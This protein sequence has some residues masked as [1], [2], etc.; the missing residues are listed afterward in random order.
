MID[1]EPNTEEFRNKFDSIAAVYQRAFAGFPWFEN[2]SDAEVRRRMTDSSSK[3]GFQAFIEKGPNGEV[4]GALWYDTPS[5]EQL[6]LERGQQLADTAK[7][8]CQENNLNNIIWEREVIADPLFQRRGIATGLRTTF[9]LHLANTFPGGALILT[10]MRDD[11][12]GIIK[13]AEKLGYTRTG[14]RLPSSQLAGV[15]H[16]YWDKIIFSSNDQN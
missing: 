14:I 10:R 2:L 8:I 6:S 11:N 1:C 5:L 3:T 13:V 9:L 15:F 7:V 4:V 16:E 12:I